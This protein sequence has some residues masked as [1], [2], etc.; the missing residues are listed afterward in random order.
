M[1]LPRRIIDYSGQVRLGPA[2]RWYRN[3]VSIRHSEKDGEPVGAGKTLCASVRKRARF[4]KPLAS[5][6]QYNKTRASLSVFRR[7]IS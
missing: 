5:C 4:E 6:E 7:F 3:L 2:S 1:G